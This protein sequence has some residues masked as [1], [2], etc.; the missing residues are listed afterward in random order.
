[1]LSDPTPARPGHV[2]AMLFRRPQTFF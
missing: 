2:R 1:L